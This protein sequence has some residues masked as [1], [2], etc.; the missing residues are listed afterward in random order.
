[1]YTLHIANKNYSSWSLRPW[2]LMKERGIDFKEVQTVF[3]SDSNWNN[4]REFCPTGMVP[5]L[6][7]GDQTVWDSLAICE[8]LAESH[9]GVWPDNVQAR[10]WARCAAA[11]MHSGFSALRND[12]PMNC[13]IRVELHDISDKLQRDIS[14]LDELLGEGLKRF[15]GPFLAGQN[16]TT[17]DAFYAP[18][19]FRVQSY[20]LELSD[21]VADYMALLLSLSSMTAW[22]TSAYAEPWLEESHEEEA[23]LAGTILKDFRENLEC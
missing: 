18:V 4:F 17:V 22:Q 13:G 6:Q 12:C 3:S 11:E 10:A 21:T 2:V 9:S 5:C 16:F 7:D 1:M 15:G 14:R 19:A 23:R 8:Y 20:N